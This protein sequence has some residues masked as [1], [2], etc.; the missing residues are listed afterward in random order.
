M[1]ALLTIVALMVAP[2]QAD[3]Q[4]AVDPSLADSD[5]YVPIYR[6]CCQED[7]FTG[8]MGGVYDLGALYIPY[9]DSYSVQGYI[10]Q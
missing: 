6:V 1:A 8:E 10:F 4:E 7:E 2:V 3:V 5:G 9:Y